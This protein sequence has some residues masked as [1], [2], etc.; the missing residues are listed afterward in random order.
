MNWLFVIF[1]CLAGASLAVQSGINGG[2]G[3]K[4]G[5]IEAAFVS[6]S[7]GTLV[8][9]LMM[10]FAGKGN[11][12]NVLSVPKWQLLGGVLGV[13]VVYSMVLAVPRIGVATTIVSI[14]VGQIVT[15]MILDH[16]GLFSGKQIPFDFNRMLAVILLG[17]A[18]FLI[19]KK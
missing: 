14:I 4:I 19:Y 2:L 15:S 9:L 18:L 1:V 7:I 13:I 3:K 16:M 10:I 6:F 5:S 8:L 12:L 11:I 17:V